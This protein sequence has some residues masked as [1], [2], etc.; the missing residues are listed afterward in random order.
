[1]IWAPCEKSCA[2]KNQ[3]V[4]RGEERAFELAGEAQGLI[5]AKCGNCGHEQDF[6]VEEW[7]DF[8]KEMD[9]RAA[10]SGASRAGLTR[11]PRIEPHTG[12][13]VNSRED[14]KRAM[15]A[16]GM[17]EAPHGINEQYND[18]TCEKLKSAR[19]AREAKKLALQRKRLALNRP[20][21]DPKSGKSATHR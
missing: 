2:E 12:L 18:E 6:L 5:W 11:Y 9:L 14:E 16:M 3:Y 20:R 21:K 19:Q 1:M 15:K 10:R 8:S 13:L 7:N 17:H 4:C